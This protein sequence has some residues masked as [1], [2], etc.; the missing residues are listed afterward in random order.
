MS[1]EIYYLSGTGNSLHAAKELGK[2]I[3]DTELIP[4]AG[5]KDKPGISSKRDTVGFVFPV[6]FMTAPKIVFRVLERLDLHSAQYIFA[7]ATRCETPC[8]IMYEQIEKILKKKGKRLDSYMTV[9]MASNDP[10]FRNWKPC[11]QEKLDAMEA[12]LQRK[13]DLFRNIVLNREEFH[14]EDREITFQVSPLAERLGVLAAAFF[15][16]GRE[17]FYADPGCSGCGTCEK[18]CPSSKIRM[19]NGKPEWQ[20]KHDC[21]SCYACLNFCPEKAV[22]LKSTP[23]MKFY[24]EQNGRYLHPDILRDE[25]AA[26]KLELTNGKIEG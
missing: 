23:P 11:P 5:L 8:R 18:V 22:Q 4:I 19:V 13:L 2:R 12:V 7:V 26:Q 16:D 6:H 20:K 3:P 15:G 24:T 10:K 1:A 17:K 14:E 21:F 9:T 25:I